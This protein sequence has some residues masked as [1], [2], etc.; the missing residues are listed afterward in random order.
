MKTYRSREGIIVSFLVLLSSLLTAGPLKAAQIIAEPDLFSSGTDISSAFA[1]VTLSCTGTSDG[2]VYAYTDI[3]HSTGTNVFAFNSGS[4]TP[5]WSDSYIFRATFSSPVSTIAIDFI[6]DDS[7]DYGTLKA[8]NSVGTLLTTIN[9]PMLGTGTVYTAQITRAGKDIAYITANGIGGDVLYLDHLTAG[10][11]SGLVITPTAGLISQG[12]RGGPFIPSAITYTLL[13]DNAYDINWTAGATQSWVT[14]SLASGTLPAGDSTDVEVSLNSNADSLPYGNYSDIVNFT[15]TNSGEILPRSVQLAVREPQFKLLASDGVS[16]DH[17]GIAVSIDGDYAIVGAADDDDKGTSSGSA[18]IFQKNG[19]S[20]G[21]QA[22]LTAS[23]GTSSDYFGISVSISG[24]YAIVGAYSDDDMGSS[25]GSAYIFQRSGTS[26][27]QQ[28]KLVPS[29]GYSSDYFGYSVSISGDYA[30]VGAYYDDDRG[31]DSGSAYIFQRSG[32]SWSQQAKLTAADGLSSDI[33]GY[34]VSI[35]GDYAIVGAYGDDDMGS[36]SGSAYIFQR[37]GTSWS[38]Q[39]KLLASDGV[40]SDYFGRSVSIS[41][42]YAIAGA[43]GNDDMGSTSGSAYIFQRSGTIWAQQAKLVPSDGYS[44]DSFGYSV[45]IDG[46]YAIAGAYYDDDKGTDSGSAYVFQRNG[47]SWSQQKK[48]VAN[49]GQSSDCLGYS[50]AISD[51]L[52]IAGAI[53]DDDKGS[54]AGSAYIFGSSDPLRINPPAGLSSVGYEEGPFVPDSKQ[55]TFSNAGPDTLDWYASST[56]P[57]LDIQ[58]EEGTLEPNDSIIVTVTVNAEAGTLEPNE[59]AGL[60]NFENIT[61]GQIQTLPAALLVKRRPGQV[62]VTDSIGDPYD[63]NMPFGDVIVGLSRTE[64]VTISNA[65][66]LNEVIIT[67]ISVGGGYLEDFNDGMAQDWSEDVNSDWSVTAGEYIAYHP[68][69]VTSDS[70][71]ATYAGQQWQDFYA[72]ISMRRS[73]TGSSRYL[74]VKSSADFD[75]YPNQRGSAYALGIDATN[76]LVFKLVNGTNTTLQGW[77]SSSFI[78]PPEQSNVLGVNVVGTTIEFYINGHLVWTGSDSSLTSG[79]AGMLAYTTSGTSPIMHY[80]DDVFVGQPL[81]QSQQISDEQMWYNQHAY[82]FSEITAQPTDW[83]P[84]E[85]PGIG[86]NEDLGLLSNRATCFGLAGLP[87]FP[88]VIPPGSSIS[89]DVNFAP[90]AIDS[91][92]SLLV[93]ETEDVNGGVVEVNLNGAGIPDFLAVTP[94]A[95]LEFSGHPGGPFVPTYHNYQLT[96]NGTTPLSWT[97]TCDVAWLNLPSNSGLIN[98]GDTFGLS[99][100]TNSDAD[101]LPVGIYQANLV[102]RNIDTGK[103]HIRGVL[104]NVFTESKIWVHPE[105]FTVIVPFGKTHNEVITIGNGGGSAL[106]FEMSARQT[107]FAP[108][109]QEYAAGAN[110]DIPADANFAPNR[111]LVRFALEDDEKD[112]GKFNTE[113]HAG[114]LSKLGLGHIKKN[115]R[116][117][118]GLCLVELPP[119][120]NV[121]DAIKALKAS[122]KVLYAEPDY[123]VHALDESQTIPNDP[124]FSQQWNMHNTGQGGGKIDAD[125]DAPEAWDEANQDSTTIVAVIDTGVEYTHPDLSAIM[126]KNQ[127]ELNGTTGVDDDDNGYIDDIYGY[128]FCTYGKSR[129]SDPIDDNGH[130]SHVSGIIG[131][132]ANNNTGVA[133]VARNVKIMAVK[134]LSSGGSGYDSDAVDAVEYCTLMKANIMSNS[135]GGSLSSTALQDAIEAAD[136]A[137]IL[138]VAAAG[139][140]ASNTDS[141]PN[142]PSGYPCQNIISVAAT[143]FLDNL[144]S[145]SNWGLTTVDLGAPGGDSGMGVYSCWKGGGYSSISG[146]SMACPHVAGA[147]AVLLSMC[148]SMPHTLVKSI[149]MNS[150]DPLPA[151]NGKC[152]SGG[153]LNL[154]NAVVAAQEV[155]SSPWIEFLPPTGTVQAGGIAEVNVIFNGNCDP[156]TYEGYITVASNDLLTPETYISV[157][158]VV[159]PVDYL[160][161]MFDPCQPVDP[162]DPNCNDLAY[163]TI[164]FVPNGSASYYAAGIKEA[165]GFRIDPADATP[166][167]LGDDD[168][169]VVDL[170]GNTINFY[171][172]QYDTLYIGSNG[173]IT[174]ESGD[175]NRAESFEEHFALPRISALFDDLDPSSGGTISVNRLH[176]R[177]VVTFENVHEFGQSNANSFQIELLYNGRIMLTLLEIAAKDGLVGLS[178]GTSVPEYF[179]ESDFTA[180]GPYERQADLNSDM[181]VDIS[182]FSIMANL[183]AS[184]YEVGVYETATDAFGQISFGNNDGTVNFAGDWLESGES[185]GPAQGLLQIVD[186]PYNSMRIGSSVPNNYPATSLTRDVNLSGATSAA[187]SYYYTVGSSAYN[188]TVTVEVSTNGSDWASIASYD[189]SSGFGYADIDIS[190]YISPT[191]KIRFRSSSHIRMFLYIEYLEVLYEVES[192]YY[193]CDFNRDL[194]VDID[195]LKTFCEQWLQ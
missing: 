17:F 127:A 152:V 114:V 175:I 49:D 20:W 66:I 116:I 108:L 85:F 159:E 103:E 46:D 62:V 93:I 137:G 87:A 2:R 173:Y 75:M 11:L 34:S 64:Q 80:F 25:S 142:Y 79:R 5:Y 9:T 185:D 96:N 97:V 128:D 7:S 12:D 57:W 18:Y 168:Y 78:K 15:D 160:T 36:S 41:G 86:I 38:Q 31:T 121:R 84:P 50:V 191:T 179:S 99:I 119:N 149:L 161:E 61:S 151:L 39:A 74:L 67:N 43:Y 131:A 148:P 174:F 72:E 89:F 59:Y 98:P 94:D 47:T 172:Q 32:T 146:T 192:P 190:S 92:Q 194:T 30:I 145:Y 187:L 140:N 55:Y 1:G 182:D 189:P 35:S 101:T 122:G 24:D 136:D 186:N 91:Y 166:V 112:A 138:F 147:S 28:A 44:S 51:Q 132:V 163:H 117:V 54:D 180:Y 56:C 14:V 130:G 188:G 167:A 29:D 76:F 111:L 141:Y 133:G 6:G 169:S 155:C 58:P 170:D 37:S 120:K 26:W 70:M 13:N 88:V 22:K 193:Q 10:P 3:Y 143:S 115:Y 177:I 157:T 164:T 23:D 106:D 95:N 124:A 8:Y 171:G 33:F 109:G 53:Y 82:Q 113:K 139:N 40:S 105:S 77:T 4:I 184:N 150:V 118:N 45:S 125:I 52:S 107:N 178:K 123:E 65:D 195:D 104:L 110:Y 126:W 156:G 144:S 63:H 21:Q 27:V 83:T 42:D 100:N 129:D 162:C 154:Y 165:S 102:F 68:S 181:I 183:W 19:A 134:F 135:W 158:M 69:P 90:E 81:T 153:R 60:I 71:V 176:D 16:S 73:L 48:L